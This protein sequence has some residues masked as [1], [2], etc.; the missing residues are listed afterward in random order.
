MLTAGR[1]VHVNASAGIGADADADADVDKKQM[2]WDGMRWDVG[3]F[4]SIQF[5]NNSVRMVGAYV[6]V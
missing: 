6:A 3:W 5:D 1:G 4:D 2:G